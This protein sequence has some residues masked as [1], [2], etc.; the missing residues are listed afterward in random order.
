MT[1]R[2]PHRASGTRC[3]LCGSAL[4]NAIDGWPAINA[5]GCSDSYHDGGYGSGMTPGYC[6]VHRTTWLRRPPTE[7]EHRNAPWSEVIEDWK[8]SDEEYR[9]QL[10]GRITARLEEEFAPLLDRYLERLRDDL[11]D[12][13]VVIVIGM[14]EDAMTPGKEL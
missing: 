9:V 3:D 13:A 8:R 5:E 14:V 2:P 1:D 7:E 6:G 4:V 11:L 10:H 12:E